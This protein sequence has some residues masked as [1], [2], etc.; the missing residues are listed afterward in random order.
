MRRF[1][2]AP[3][4]LRQRLLGNKLP[5]SFTVDMTNLLSQADFKPGYV[6]SRLAIFRRLRPP[7][8]TWNSGRSTFEPSTI[9]I[10]SP[11]FLKDKICHQGFKNDLM[12]RE[13][14]CEPGEKPDVHIYEKALPEF[15]A[16]RA[17]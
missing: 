15:D 5:K 10:R 4:G 17:S 12:L 2:G 8:C 3:K 13:N 11:G 6:A 9:E 1:G 7:S 14:G 16:G